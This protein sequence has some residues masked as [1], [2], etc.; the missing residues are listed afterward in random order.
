M[1]DNATEIMQEL[2]KAIDL[3]LNGQETPKRNGFCIF[4]FPFDGLEGTNTNYVSN[5]KREDVRSAMK[6][7]LARWE[8][9]PQA[10]GR[11]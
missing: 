7:V 10:S 1:S 5:A 4:V 2:A 8:G 11:A 3:C 6:E 9:Q